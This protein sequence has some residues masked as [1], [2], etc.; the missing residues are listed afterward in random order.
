MFAQSPKIDEK[1]GNISMAE[2]EM[3]V[4]PID[5]N[6]AAVILFDIG[7]TKFEY[8]TTDRRF[9]LKIERRIRLKVLNK[10][11]LDWANVKISLYHESEFMERLTEFKGFTYNLVDGK[12]QKDKVEKSSIFEDKKNDNRT[13]V[14]VVFP[15]VVAGSIIEYKY[16]IISDYIYNLQPWAFQHSIP[17][18]LSRY[19][20][21]IPEY[22]QYNSHIT[23]YEN[24]SVTNDEQTRTIVF[25]TK[26]YEMVSGTSYPKTQ[27][28]EVRYAESIKTYTAQ[29]VSALNDESYVDDI[30]NY[31]TKVV[32]EL[33][34]KRFPGETQKN[35]ALSW[36][37]I[38][39][40]L[41]DNADFGRQLDNGNYLSDELKAYVGSVEKPEERLLKVIAFIKSKIKWNDNYR[42]YSSDGVKT[43]YLNGVGSSSDLNLNLIVALREV[44]FEAYPIA[45]STRFHGQVFEWQKTVTGFNHVIAGVKVADKM[46]Y[47]DATSSFNTYLLLPTECLNGQARLIDSKKGAWV[48]L[49]SKTISRK[50]VYAMLKINENSDITGTVDVNYKD[51]FALSL[52]ESVKGDDSLKRRKEEINKILNNATIDSLKIKFGENG[53]PDVKEHYEI[54]MENSSQTGLDI[55]YFSPMSGFGIGKNPFVKVERKFPVNFTYPR[56]ETIIVKYKIPAGFKVEEVPV[57]A[58]FSMP[59]NKAKFVMS[60][61]VKDDE[62]V[63]MCKLTIQNTLYVSENYPTLRG[64][65]DEVIKKQNEQVVLK[66]I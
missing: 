16:E 22:Y 15:K 2:M 9:R 46:V 48:D 24:V 53:S 64:F 7:E 35:Y 28:D 37:D 41:L 54:K 42:L 61:Q 51:Y 57:N 55:I 26:V 33:A 19:T 63:V 20:V 11:G 43:A 6:A 1:F 18:L 34:V 17:V 3:K 38:N 32:F 25:V 65:F 49:N 45:L 40:K 47:C 66:K 56:D 52:A 58:A 4:C 29:N 8:N 44:G 12:L 13:I 39:D 50:S 59:E 10:D 21:G 36:E 14:K 31:L 60:Y 23:G 30:D 27:R 5:S 62:L